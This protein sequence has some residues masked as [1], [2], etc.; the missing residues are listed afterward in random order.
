MKNNNL[1]KVASIILA[2]VSICICLF[3]WGK[4]SGFEYGYFYGVFQ[5]P[6]STFFNASGPNFFQEINKWYFIITVGFCIYIIGK[7]LKSLAVSSII[8][9]LSLSVGFYPYW[10]MLSYKKE[11]LAMETKF[12][13]DYWLNKSVYFDWFLLCQYLCQLSSRSSHFSLMNTP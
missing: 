13:Y 7:L 4:V 5:N 11:I 9:I 3:I 1:V 8:C 2:S 10:D 12:P 6:P